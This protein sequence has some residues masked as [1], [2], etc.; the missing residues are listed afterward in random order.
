VYQYLPSAPAP[1][2]SQWYNW[3]CP[4]TW[5]VDHF[6]M[7]ASKV[8]LAYFFSGKQ[9]YLLYS[10]SVSGPGSVIVGLSCSLLTSMQITVL[11]ASSQ[12]AA[13]GS[14]K[15]TVTRTAQLADLGHDQKCFSQW[16]VLV[17]GHEGVTSS[18]ISR[19]D[20]PGKD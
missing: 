9:G 12:R 15:T 2:Q 10:L 6:G 11:T 5:W 18:V 20:W 17:E 3:S 16:R 14:P 7:H 1:G 8:L 13:L 19:S 4:D